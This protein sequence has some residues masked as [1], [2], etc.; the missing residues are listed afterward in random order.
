MNGRWSHVCT[1]GNL[2]WCKFGERCGICLKEEDDSLGHH[3]PKDRDRARPMT[4]ADTIRSLK[5]GDRVRVT[6][7]QTIKEMLSD[8]CAMTE[9]GPF[10]Q[11]ND[12]TI[13]SIEVIER[14]LAVGDRVT[15][16]GFD[17]QGVITAIGKHYSLVE[18]DCRA[19]VPAMHDDL[20]R[21]S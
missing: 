12:P 11:P 9:V 1:D 13:T 16:E 10:I 8:V 5:P 19:E 3:G 20:R 14:P 18:L 2:Q 21:A 6:R 4:I 15:V 7:D 17:E